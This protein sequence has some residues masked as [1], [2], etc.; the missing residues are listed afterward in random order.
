MINRYKLSIL[1]MLMSLLSLSQSSAQSFYKYEVQKV[2]NDVFVLKPVISDYR[3]VTSNI[4]LIVNENDL[5]VVDSGLLPDAGSEAIKEIKKIS[6]KP[7]RYLVNTHWHGD[8]WQGN[9]AFEKTF[10]R[11]QII[12]TEQGKKGMEENGLVWAR[13][14]YIKHFEN[15]IGG[16]DKAI[17]EKSLDGKSL[18]DAEVSNLKIATTQFKQDLEGMKHLNPVLPN[19][20]FSERVVITSGKREIDFLYLGVGNTSGDAV[21][22]LPNEKIVIAGDL[23]VHPSPYES[24]MFSPEW[25]ETSQKLAALD[26]QILIPGHGEVQNGK[27][28][29]NFLNSLFAEIIKQVKNAYLSNGISGADDLKKAV[30]HKSVTDELSKVNSNKPFIGKLESGFIPQA[31]QTSFKRIIQGKK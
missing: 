15:Y 26:F 4:V 14:L 19:V 24:G 7:V 11:I 31:I 18:S 30:T 10:P 6:S 12:A 1:T 20:T 29:L 13:K 23:V 5:L 28:Y 3:W 17:A 27:D 22:Y 8:H 2:A 21:L 16:Y 9:E 25:L